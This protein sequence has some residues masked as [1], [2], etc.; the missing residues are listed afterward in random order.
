MNMGSIG[1]GLVETFN[2][3][4]RTAK[5]EIHFDAFKQ[6]FTV[7]KF[8]GDDGFGGLIFVKQSFASTIEAARDAANL[9]IEERA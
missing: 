7:E 5:A 8:D 2:A 9:W 3:V 6:R 1:Y 4:S